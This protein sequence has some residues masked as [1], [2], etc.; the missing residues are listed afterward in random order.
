LV[1]KLA[2]I[3]AKDA[4]SGKVPQVDNLIVHDKG[5]ADDFA[6]AIE[7]LTRQGWSVKHIWAAGS[8]HFALFVRK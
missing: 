5:L 8:F 6:A 3:G 4:I 1:P 2:S 7:I